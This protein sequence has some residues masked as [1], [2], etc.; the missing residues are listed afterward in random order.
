[1]THYTWPYGVL[2]HTCTPEDSR[3]LSPTTTVP[4]TVGYWGG[5]SRSVTT[6]LVEKMYVILVWKCDRVNIPAMW[7]LRK[8]TTLGLLL[9]EVEVAQIA[10]H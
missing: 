7:D 5:V 2:E 4:G 10:W 3:I 8:H 9:R 6:C 1:M